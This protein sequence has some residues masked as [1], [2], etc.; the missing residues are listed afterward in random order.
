MTFPRQIASAGLFA[1]ILVAGCG[2]GKGRVEAPVLDPGKM[3]DQAMELCDENSDGMLTTAELKASPA[4]TFA[5]DD[6]DT[7]G[8]GKLSRDE[9]LER[10]KIYEEMN[11]GL[12]SI[13][14]N[15]RHRSKDGPGLVGA[16]VRLI[17]EPFMAD[18]IDEC[19]GEVI[20]AEMGYVNIAAMP[21][22]PG[23]RV[24]MYRMEITS[25]DVKIPAKYNT[26]SALGIEV[27]PI[28]S[29]A[30]SE[31]LIYVIR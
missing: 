19:E 13:T 16:K 1:V 6:I 26:N 20:D 17:P 31:A 21:P 8:D 10:F 5:K 7:D 3:T 28:T 12:Q 15:V 27:P 29:R 30:T 22:D 9:L 4:L 24:G 2:E 14:L 23:V 11:V 25:D 18:F